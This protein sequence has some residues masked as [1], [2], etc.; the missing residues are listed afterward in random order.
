M[1]AT[2]I[3]NKLDMNVNNTL[4]IGDYPKLFFSIFVYLI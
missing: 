2:W 1:D 4:W 3:W